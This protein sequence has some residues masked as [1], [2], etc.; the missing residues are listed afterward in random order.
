[1]KKL[2]LL[3]LLINIT[4]LS[5][6][7]GV[8]KFAVEFNDKNSTP[9]SLDEPSDFLSQR[10]IDRRVKYNIGYNETDLPIDPQYIANVLAATSDA[11]LI[12]Q[13]KWMNTILISLSDSS[14][15]ELINELPSVANIK[16]VF[17]HS[18]KKSKG[19]KFQSKFTTSEP[20]ANEYFKGTQEFDSAF[21]GGAWV[22]TH[23]MNVEKMHQQGFKGQGMVIAVLDAGFISAD[24]LRIFQS[25]WDNNQ[26]LG[27]KNFVVPGMT[28]FAGHSHGTSV[29]STMGGYWE[30][31]LVGTAPEADYW[32]IRTE[33]DTQGTETVTEE[34]NW[35]AGAAFADSVG[36]DV[37]NTSLGY[38]TFDDPSQ[39]HTWAD[40]D[41]NKTVITRGA[42][43]AYYKG[44]LPVNSAGNSG[45][46]PWRYIGAP[47]DGTE[48]FSI[49]AVNGDGELASFS[50]I[51]FPW[52]DDVK[53]NVV[54]RGAGTYVASAYDNVVGQSNGTSFS[55]PVM[56]GAI[57]SLWSA[58]PSLSPYWIK[59]AIEKSSSQ[60]MQP[61]TLLGYG[62]PN[63]QDALNI[64]G[65]NQIQFGENFLS[66]SPNPMETIAYLTLS[67]IE[68]SSFDMNIYDI[69][70]RLI[71]SEERVYTGSKMPINISKLHSGIFILEVIMDNQTHR[72]KINKL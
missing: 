71:E 43:M 65:V 66:V 59:R 36:A 17:S 38:T 27:T 31:T 28:V 68:Q 61:D 41:G 30:G 56:A 6:S 49:G 42:N 15:I 52:S 18:W 3:A 37:L 1:M 46:K 21:Y 19:A 55:S 9:F 45:N 26:I 62:I 72:L 34:Y 48:V 51:G 2:L 33:D 58:D 5:Q 32:L 44:M 14:N 10:A 54:A 47:A 60:Y 64:L 12:I 63:F 69:Q 57:A 4:I 8:Y 70:G 24:T 25:L 11:K 39:D 16:L 67:T 40:L 23:Q 29:L 53:P 20:L 50:S 35:V 22:Q 13:V 7:Q